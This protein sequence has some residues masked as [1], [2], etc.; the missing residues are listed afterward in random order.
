MPRKP[1]DYVDKELR[2]CPNCGSIAKTPCHDRHGY[3][4]GRWF[5][6][7]DESE[8]KR[9]TFEEGEYNES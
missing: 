2:K 5:C 4:N 1:I 6:P 3:Y 8:C 9:Y 7:K